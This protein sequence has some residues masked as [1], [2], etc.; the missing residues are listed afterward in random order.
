MFTL[1]MFLT[2]LRDAGAKAVLS[3]LS[4]SIA[5]F[6]D[7]EVRRY[8]LNS[9]KELEENAERIGS[10]DTIFT[11]SAPKD[12]AKACEVA[13]SIADSVAKATDLAVNSEE[14]KDFRQFTV[15]RARNASELD[16]LL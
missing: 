11:V 3:V 1:A 10:K 12:N 8:S 6:R 9:K 4:F 5:K 15:G 2:I 16:A 13:R 14:Y 7:G